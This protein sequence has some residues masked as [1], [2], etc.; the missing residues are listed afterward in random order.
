MAPP[1]N[2]GKFAFLHL[3]FRPFFIGAISFAIIAMLLW[4]GIYNLGW[5]IQTYPPITWH[6]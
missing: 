6:A 5:D 4:M 3:G 2:V 1:K